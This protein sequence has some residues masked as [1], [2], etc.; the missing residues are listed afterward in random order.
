MSSERADRIEAIFDRLV[1]E[2]PEQQHRLLGELCEGDRQLEAD[3]R[4]LLAADAADQPILRHNGAHL[5]SVLLDGDEAVPLPRQFGRYVIREYLGEG[6]MGSVYLADRADLGDAVAVKFLND[7]WT[8]PVRRRRFAAEQQTLARLNHPHIAR[9]YDAGVADGTPW[10]A[11]EYVAGSTITDYCAEKRT[12]LRGRVRLFR[13][14]CDAVS[15]AH[16]SLTVHLDLKPANVLVN[17]S[18]DVKLVDFGIARHVTEQGAAIERTATGHRLLSVNYAS[19]EQIRGEP[20][21][22]QS[23]VHALGVMLYELLVGKPPADL[24]TTNPAELAR[25]LSE[26]PRRPSLAAREDGSP[27][28]HASRAQWRDLDVICLTALHRHKAARYGSVDKLIADV[29]HFLADEPLD[30][31]TGHL[32]SYRFRKFMSRHRRAVAAAAAVVAIVSAL[33]AFFTLRLIDARDRALASEARTSR[34]NRLMLNLFEGDDSA[35]GPAGGLR[36]VSLLDRGVRELDGLNADRELQAELRHTFGGLYHKLGHLDRAQ[37]LLE[38]A[39]T[40]RQSVLGRDHPQT[41]RAQLGL[42]LLQLDQSRMD[43]AKRLVREALDVARQ[44][45]RIDPTEV[46]I[47]KAALGKVLAT[48]GDYAAA[49][50]LLEESIDHLSTQPASVDLSEA[51]GDLGNTEYYLGRVEAAQATNVRGLALDRQLFGDRHPFVAVDL[52]NLG[53]LSLDRGDYP[54]GEALFRQALEIND[55]WY[56]A[57]HPKTASNLLMVGRSLAY[58]GR[59]DEAADLYERARLAMRSA[60]GEVHPRFGGVLSLIGDLARDQGELDRAEQAFRQAAD[61]FKQTVGERHEA[62]LYQLSNLGSVHLARKAYAQA[63]TL[64]RASVKGLMEVVPDQRLTGIAQVRLGATLAA[65]KR[66]DEAERQVLAG[67]QT[68][69][70]LPGSASAELQVARKELVGIYTAMNL[71]AKADEFRDRR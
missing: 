67:Y 21:D 23:D 37:P 41:I 55:A 11:M 54:G 38:S 9:L 12:D 39:W 47:A 56:G 27:L 1:D 16:R 31:R 18:G 60:Y 46:A 14:V 32:H 6:G 58:Q 7:S 42:A 25:L 8:S 33:T 51:L 19:P 48:E 10:F 24:S 66:Y 20:V 61:I 53:N 2:S 44:R 28:V 22:V 62:Y 26:Q 30:A 69:R 35:A 43:D 57:A 71:P 3:V 68:L 34:I 65:Q 17:A 59:L 50:P 29:D 5:A 64:G 70:R 36:V 15:Y 52:Y 40:S 63:E 13:A 49:V 4:A 45:S